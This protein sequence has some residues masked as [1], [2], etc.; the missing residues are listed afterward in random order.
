MNGEES[1]S[2]PCSPEVAG[3]SRKMDN[4]QAI[5]RHSEKYS[6]GESAER[7][8]ADGRTLY[9]AWV[10]EAALSRRGRRSVLLSH[11]TGHLGAMDHLFIPLSSS[12]QMW[13]FSQ[14]KTCAP[15]GTWEQ[16]AAV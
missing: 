1:R 12:L 2:C 14:R 15:E 4:K 5:T 16:V 13:P 6:E 7:S 9:P 3:G 10:K 11:P 8:G